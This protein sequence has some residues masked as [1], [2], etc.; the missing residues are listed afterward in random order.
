M[1]EVRL[2]GHAL[3]FAVQD[4]LQLFFGRAE[5]DE[6][7]GLLRAPRGPTLVLTSTVGEEEVSTL[8]ADGRGPR[9]PRP[10]DER[11]LRRLLRV[12]LYEVLARETGRS[13]PWGSLTGI[14]PTWLVRERRLAG[15]SQLAIARELVRFYHVM[16]A[17]A[18][19]A[20]AAE[21]TERQQ[22][23]LLKPGDVLLYLHIPFCPSRCGYCSFVTAT[24]VARPATEHRDYVAA[25]LR[26]MEDFFGSDVWHRRAAAGCRIRALY[27]GGGTPISLAPEAFELLLAGLDRA[28]PLLAEARELSIE[29]GRPDCVTPAILARL[30]EAGFTRICINPQSFDDHLLAAAGRPHGRRES[31][32]AFALARAAG[33]PEIHMDLIGGLPG[34]TGATLLAD[35]RRALE[36]GPESLTLHALAPKRGADWWETENFRES[37]DLVA[38]FDA[39]TRL[40]RRRG[41]RPGPLYRQKRILAGLENCTHALPGRGGL[42]NTAMLSDE[43]DVLGFGASAMTK[44]VL[45][46]GRVKRL[47]APRDL[48]LYMARVAELGRRRRELW[49]EN[50]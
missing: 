3:F 49:E 34:G 18:R 26:D 27:V 5:T 4:L 38:G 14:R 28:A 46:P 47:A 24:G 8:R 12:Q 42:Y 25:L 33:F 20:L 29:A 7:A 1:L 19:L 16:P 13:F 6:A 23:D 15:W 40:L 22:L 41:Y 39:A 50:G 30:R 43:A 11:L 10:A 31:E 35:V 32:A 17:R 9:A 2:R 37:T 48:R 21:R 36:L 45:A 44:R